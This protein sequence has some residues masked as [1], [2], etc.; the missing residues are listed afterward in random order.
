MLCD[1]TVKTYDTDICFNDFP[2]NF[3]AFFMFS[4]KISKFFTDFPGF[5]WVL[6]TLYIIYNV[7]Y[8]QSSSSENLVIRN[9]QLNRI[10]FWYIGEKK[11]S[12]NMQ[13]MEIKII[14]GKN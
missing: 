6:G 11:F 2:I 13:C 9:C 8:F 1:N 3:P 7:L 5:T 4:L 10:Y 14:K 12:I